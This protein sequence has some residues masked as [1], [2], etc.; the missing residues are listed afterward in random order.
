MAP[1]VVEKRK[2]KA[3]KRWGSRGAAQ[4]RE[5][6]KSRYTKN[7]EKNACTSTAETAHLEKRK[8]GRAAWSFSTQRLRPSASDKR[9]RKERERV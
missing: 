1:S 2:G 8:R 9:K 3:K 5:T 6:S 7:E 4:K